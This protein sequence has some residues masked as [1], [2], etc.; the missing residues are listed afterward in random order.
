M[1][2]ITDHQIHI[3][4]MTLGKSLLQ[5]SRSGSN[6]HRNL[7]SSLAPEPMKGFEYTK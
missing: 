7:L 2:T 3:T 6:G 4:L 5:R 1:L